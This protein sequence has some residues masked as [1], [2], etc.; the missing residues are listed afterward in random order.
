M[1]SAGSLSICVNRAKLRTSSYSRPA[2]TLERQA[3]ED[4]I[5]RLRTRRESL[6]VTQSHLEAE[7]GVADGLVAKWETFARLPSAFMLVCWC[8]SLNV[9]LIPVCLES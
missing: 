6:R 8:N 1:S 7:L 4:I 2:S 5:R 9:T 3:F